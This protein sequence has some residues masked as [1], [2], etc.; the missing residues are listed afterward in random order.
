MKKIVALLILAAM[1]ATT[2]CSCSVD[3]QDMGS[4]IPMYLADPQTDLDPTDMIYDKDFIKVSSLVFEG[5]TQVTSSGE[6]EP[7]IEN[8]K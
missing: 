3:M 8:I 1:L 4:I 6:I 7:L 5:L 2:L